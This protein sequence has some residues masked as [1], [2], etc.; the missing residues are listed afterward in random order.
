L[1]DD[2][3]HYLA[4]VKNALDAEFDIVKTV[5]NGQAVVEEARK[6]HPALI[7]LDITMPILSGIDAARQLKTEGF[8]GKIVFLTVHNDRDY[9]HAAQAAGAHGYVVKNRL[10]TDLIPAIHDV[11]AG[12]PFVSPVLRLADN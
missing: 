1:A 7:I 2:H 6:L 4:V 12:A 5:A 9:V 10:A 11:M 8:K 3:P